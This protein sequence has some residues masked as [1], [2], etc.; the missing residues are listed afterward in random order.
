MK[1][2]VVVI[3]CDV[4]NYAIVLPYFTRATFKAINVKI[5]SENTR[6][7]QRKFLIQLIIQASIPMLFVMAPALIFA[8]TVMFDI[9]GIPCEYT[10][11]NN[12][13]NKGPT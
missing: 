9:F 8:P 11:G 3:W 7:M 1:R 2:T 4:I 10:E 13:A 5:M 12:N 6:R